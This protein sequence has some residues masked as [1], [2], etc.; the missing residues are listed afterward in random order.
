MIIRKYTSINKQK[1]YSEP[2]SITPIRDVDKFKIMKWRNE[3]I[4]HLRQSKE[5]TKS[6][7]IK[8]FNEIINPQFNIKYPNQLLFSFFKNDIIKGYGGLVHIDWNSKNAEISFLMNTEEEKPY[9]EIY[10]TNFIFMIEELA[11]KNL[12]FK[13]LYVY[14]FNLRP[15]LYKVLSDNNFYEEARLK[16]HHFY[17]DNFIDVLIHSKIKSYD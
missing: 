2:F 6:Q 1:F 13:K 17:N 16:D 8:Y 3:Q 9:F 7:Q 10:W 4:Y 12:N 5:I 11:F 14:S 15:N